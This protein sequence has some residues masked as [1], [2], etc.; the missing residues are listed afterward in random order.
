M[1]KILL[2]LAFPLIALGLGGVWHLLHP[3]GLWSFQRGAPTDGFPRVTWTEAAPR[4]NTAEWLLIDARTEEEYA[5]SHI[6]GA[7]SL[8]SSCFP[9]MITFF[10]EEHPR[11]KTA[12]IYC[13]TTECDRSVELAR[14]LQAEAGWTDLRILDGGMLAW[15]RS[16]P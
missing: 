11:D 8:P 3:T 6:P 16:R 4:V 10:I 1:K 2:F 9:E 15:K 12:V 14:R 13:D 5:I 7:V